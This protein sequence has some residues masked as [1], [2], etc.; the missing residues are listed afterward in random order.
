M[1]TIQA[2]A[3]IQLSEEEAEKLHCFQNAIDADTRRQF[4]ALRHRLE[5]EQ[6]PPDQ[7]RELMELTNIIEGINVSRMELLAEIGRSRGLS[8][9]AV[10]RMLNI[11]PLLS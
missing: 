9:A 3:G 7:H 11:R 6:L 5:Q 8:L 1:S 10:V 4:Q 2:E